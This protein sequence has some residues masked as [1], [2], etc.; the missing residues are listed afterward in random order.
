MNFGYIRVS[1]VDQNLERQLDD[2]ELDKVFTDKCSGGTRN[3]P[4][5][6]ECLKHC[7]E[8][9]K[10]YIHSIDRLA[11]DLCDLQNIVKELNNSGI[12]VRFEKEELTFSPNSMD[13][14]ATLTLQLMGSF[15]EFERAMIR[16][17]QREGIAIAKK[18]G[19]VA[20]RKPKLT[21]VQVEE[22]RVMLA[23]GVAKS[24]IARQFEVSRPTL[25]R[26]LAH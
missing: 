4:A 8:G 21:P 1:S 14:V 6:I 3:R 16:E 11:R 26:A 7:R 5:L 17:R 2:I 12:I 20:G 23:N 22:V 19:R 25:D 18:A 15:A 10:L 24:A 13:I 9:D